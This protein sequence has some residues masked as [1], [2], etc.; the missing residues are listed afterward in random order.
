MKVKEDCLY[1]QVYADKSY[2]LTTLFAFYCTTVIGALE[3]STQVSEVQLTHLLPSLMAGINSSHVDFT[4]S[5]FMILGHLVTKI[6]LTAG[7][8]SELF[9]KVSRVSM[10]KLEA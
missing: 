4:A 5:A 9:Y 3:Q 1:V 10:K 8:F 6:R 2:C 7:I